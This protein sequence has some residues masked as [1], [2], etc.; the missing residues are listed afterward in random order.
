M[1]GMTC[2]IYLPITYGVPY[3]LKYLKDMKLYIKTVHF[4]WENKGE[5]LQIF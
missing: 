4:D 2:H 1:Y 5:S 3:K